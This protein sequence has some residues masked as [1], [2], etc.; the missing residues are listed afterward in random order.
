MKEKGIYATGGLLGAVLASTCCLGPFVLLL[1]G[2]SG[3]WIRHLT[4]LAPYQPFFLVASLAC[5]AAGF[6]KV[7]GRTTGS[8]QEGSSCTTSQSDKLVKVAL[9]ASTLIIGAAVGVE[10]LG[11]L[12]L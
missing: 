4:A 10:T 5:L 3:A 12:F 6:W 8:C 2:V 11:P 1:F 9:W 7:Y